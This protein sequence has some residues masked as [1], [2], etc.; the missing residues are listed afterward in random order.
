M[1]EIIDHQ[2]K[3]GVVN[4]LAW[5][6]PVVLLREGWPSWSFTLDGLNYTK[7]F[8]YNEFLFS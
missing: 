6:G 1:A 2:E 7:L 8:T 5:N 3:L 4:F